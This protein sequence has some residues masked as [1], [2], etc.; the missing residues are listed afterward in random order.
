MTALGMEAHRQQLPTLGPP[1]ESRSWEHS[2]MSQLGE[3]GVTGGARSAS[4]I[5]EVDSRKWEWEEVGVPIRLPPYLT[6]GPPL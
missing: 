2:I 1:P 4:V 6:Q 3:M 5:C